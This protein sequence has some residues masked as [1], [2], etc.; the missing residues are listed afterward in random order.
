MPEWV[1][2]IS[3]KTYTESLSGQPNGPDPEKCEYWRKV[4]SLR[5]LCRAYQIP[6]GYEPSLDEM[7]EEID[8]WNWTFIQSVM[9]ADEVEWTAVLREVGILPPLTRKRKSGKGKT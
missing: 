7:V 5:R 3:K 4:A 6:T 1:E 8:K 2:T 9:M